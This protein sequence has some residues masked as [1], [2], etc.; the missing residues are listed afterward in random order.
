MDELSQL[1]QIHLIL[2][3]KISGGLIVF[4]LM[5][6]LG[7]LQ[8]TYNKDRREFRA[9]LGR[10]AK[11]LADVEKEQGRQR[12]AIVKL[13]GSVTLIRQNLRNLVDKACSEAVL[14]NRLLQEHI[15]L[16]EPV[17]KELSTSVNEVK[18][19]YA[20]ISTELAFFRE[21]NRQ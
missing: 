11:A 21:G 6:V 8:L 18:Q 13:K 12:L 9:T 7:V 20:A 15:R 4:L 16:T 14:T 19:S 1:D 2:L 17:L 10:H 3:L 5:T